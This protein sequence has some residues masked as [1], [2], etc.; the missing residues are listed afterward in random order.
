MFVWRIEA[1]RY[2]FVWC[3]LWQWVVSLLCLDYLNFWIQIFSIVLFLFHDCLNLRLRYLKIHHWFLSDEFVSLV[4][5][6]AYVRD[7]LQIY[8]VQ[9]ACKGIVCE[10]SARRS[11]NST[12]YCTREQKLKLFFEYQKVQEHF[13][14][15]RSYNPATPPT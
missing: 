13:L 1:R 9:K 15:Q 14:T 3:G 12:V 2:M 4:V 10:K 5:S 6:L 7:I 8:V 11:L